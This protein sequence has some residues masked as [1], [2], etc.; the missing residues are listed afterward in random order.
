MVLYNFKFSCLNV[1]SL[2][3]SA[4]STNGL[5]SCP[6]LQYLKNAN[7]LFICLTDTRLDKRKLD[8]IEEK[9][10]LSNSHNVKINRIFSTISNPSKRARAGCCIFFP[11]KADGQISHVLDVIKDD[12]LDEPR[13]IILVA[14]LCNGPATMIVSF[15]A[16]TNDCMKTRTDFL[17]RLNRT[18][19]ETSERHN[20]RYIILGGDANLD[21]DQKGD[22]QVKH[23]FRNMLE[24]N[25][26]SDCYRF[27]YGSQEQNKGNTFFDR[28]NIARNGSRLDYLCCSTPILENSMQKSIQLHDFSPQ[29]CDH[30]MVTCSLTWTIAGDPVNIGNGDQEFRCDASLLKNELFMAEVSSCLKKVLI[31]RSPCNVINKGTIPEHKLFAYDMLALQETFDPKYTSN[32]DY[33]SLFYELVETF[34]IHQNSFNMREYKKR[35]KQL[36]LRKKALN[37][38]LKSQPSRSHRRQIASLREELYQLGLEDIRKRAE[39]AFID[40]HTLGESATR[41]FLRSKLMNRRKQYIRSLEINNE[42]VTDSLIIEDEFQRVYSEILQEQVEKAFC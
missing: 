29:K 17:L 37:K 34:A 25:D 4:N 23:A 2:V 8:F 30:F 40:Y 36:N 14:R 42:I 24:A 1:N 10:C 21:I 26:I 12:N 11:E 9:L 28:S 15:Y 35:N 39:R 38:L 18:I 33:V 27:I 32:F 16:K 22:S 3:R 7:E 19:A 31:K 41:F 5:L 6:L 20:A 13:F